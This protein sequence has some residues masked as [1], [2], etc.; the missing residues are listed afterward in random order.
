MRAYVALA[1]LAFTAAAC[2]GSHTFTG[3]DAQRAAA[4]A[5]ANAVVLP[6]STLVFLD[7]K[8][9]PAESLSQ[10]DPKEIV[11]IEVVKGQAAVRAYGEAGRAGVISIFTR[12]GQGD[13]TA[14][15]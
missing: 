13:S 10:I 4:R 3:P 8:R 12:A 11:R 5:R 15:Q 14:H 7:G 6:T 1:V 9:L 2:E